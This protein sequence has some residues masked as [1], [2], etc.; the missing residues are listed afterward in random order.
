MTIVNIAV[1]EVL[2]FYLC[3]PLECR[4]SGIWIVRR[5][6]L[7]FIQKSD[8]TQRPRPPRKGE[9]EGGPPRGALDQSEAA[10]GP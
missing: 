3:K 5:G 9:G 8:V 4:R 1:D 2:F 7:A 10:V 6:R